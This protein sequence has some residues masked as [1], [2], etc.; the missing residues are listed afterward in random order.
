MSVRVF[1]LSGSDLDSTGRFCCGGRLVGMPALGTACVN[2]SSLSLDTRFFLDY[3]PVRCF[4]RPMYP[5]VPAKKMMM[6]GQAFNC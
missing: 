5:A 1:F 3:S 4:T 6:K 2:A